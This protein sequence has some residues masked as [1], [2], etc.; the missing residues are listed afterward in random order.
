MEQ[1][2]LFEA[3]YRLLD[4]DH[5]GE[6]QAALGKI[7]QLRDKHSWPR[8]GDLLRPFTDT[9]PIAQY[10]KLESD[11]AARVRE[12]HMLRTALGGMKTVKFAAVA[13]AVL[14][15]GLG[16]TGY[17]A[18]APD[19]RAASAAPKIASALLAD[20]KA[21]QRW[22]GPEAEGDAPPMVRTI[23][24]Q[25]YWIVIRNEVDRASHSDANGKPLTRHC[26]RY[27]VAEAQWDTATPPAW[28]TPHPYGLFGLGPIKWPEAGSQCR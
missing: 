12:V 1:P 24:G 4:S 26:Q 17:R 21:F 28:L 18:Y 27:F 14:G 5:L 8:F 19:A 13:V 6:A 15:L 23:A 9:V 22:P 20:M 2:Q 3:S 10:R 11:L 16:Y 25:P 7:H